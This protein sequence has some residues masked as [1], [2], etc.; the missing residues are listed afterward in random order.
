MV[1]VAKEVSEQQRR[2]RG[3][4]WN[5]PMGILEDNEIRLLIDS[6]KSLCDIE[7]SLYLLI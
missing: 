3:R 7:E 6:L 5:H 4:N 2:K 1:G